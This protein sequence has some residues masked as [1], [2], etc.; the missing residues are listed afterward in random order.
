MLLQE[1]SFSAVRTHGVQLRPGLICLPRGA[2][3]SQTSAGEEQGIG[4]VSLTIAY[5]GAGTAWE[6]TDFSRAIRAHR[7]AS[8]PALNVCIRRSCTRLSDC[9]MSDSCSSLLCCDVDVDCS[10]T[11]NRKVIDGIQKHHKP[12]LLSLVGLR[13]QLGK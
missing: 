2:S 4:V 3:F 6:V 1:C 7:G 5:L 10:E 11:R 12:E 8:S 13:R 9:N